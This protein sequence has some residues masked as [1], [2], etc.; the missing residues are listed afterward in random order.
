MWSSLP[1]CTCNTEWTEQLVSVYLYICVSNNNEG[2]VWEGMIGGHGQSWWEERDSRKIIS[3]YFSEVWIKARKKNREILVNELKAFD[4]FLEFLQLQGISLLEN[5]C[6]L[7]LVN[8]LEETFEIFEMA[9]CL[10]FFNHPSLC[11]PFFAQ[12]WVVFCWD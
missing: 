4:F 6:D 2:G 8:L 10:Y 1:S 7:L 9:E 5:N 3:L 11:F 12:L